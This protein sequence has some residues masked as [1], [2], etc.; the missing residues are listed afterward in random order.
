MK[1]QFQLEGKRVLVV[2][3][4]RTGIASALFCAGRG[5]RV[6]ATEEQPESRVA[7]AAAKLAAAGVRLELGGHKPETFLAQ[8]L[9]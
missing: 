6:T 9:I 4:A 2:G 7:E 8:E 1:E 5:A 3:L